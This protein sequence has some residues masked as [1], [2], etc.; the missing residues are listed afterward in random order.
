ME[1]VMLALAGLNI[2]GASFA[3]WVEWRD[4]SAMSRN[5]R[6]QSEHIKAL[7]HNNTKLLKEVLRLREGEQRHRERTLT[8]QTLDPCVIQKEGP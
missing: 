3:V 8:D 5:E 4:G 2:I 7:S 6:L 1:A